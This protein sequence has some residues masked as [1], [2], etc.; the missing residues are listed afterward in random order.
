MNDNTKRSSFDIILTTKLWF[1]IK[2]K[3]NRK[4]CFSVILKHFL[5]YIV[6]LH[7]KKIEKTR[8]NNESQFF[9]HFTQWVNYTLFSFISGKEFKVS[10]SND[11]FAS[12]FAYLVFSPFSSNEP[13]KIGVVLEF[14]QIICKI[15]TPLWNLKVCLL[16]KIPFIWPQIS[17]SDPKNMNVITIPCC[18][19]P[20]LKLFQR[21][22]FWSCWPLFGL[23]SIL[24]SLFPFAKSLWY[25]YY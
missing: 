6:F 19:R 15:R 25:T 13:N 8:K 14:W 1:W 3:K 24:S 4:A 2:Q 20:Y 21:L 16:C 23:F 11:W 17:K 7:R 22:R 18:A 10:T 5:L 12:K 9:D